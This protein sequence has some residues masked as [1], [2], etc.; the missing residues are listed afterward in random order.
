[1]SRKCLFCDNTKLTK[2]H[3][4]PK[5]IFKYIGGLGNL[6]F[7]PQNSLVGVNWTENDTFFID[8]IEKGKNVPYSDFAVKCVCADCNN[9]WMS[10]LESTVEPILRKLFDSETLG[11]LSISEKEAIQLSCWAILKTI[12]LGRL[13]IEVIEFDEQICNNLK[14]AIISDRFVVEVS[15]S[16]NTYLNYIINGQPEYIP[17]QLNRADLILEAEGFYMGGYQ[18]GN[19][20]FRV[21]YCPP[22]M[23]RMQIN[24]KMFVLFP[25]AHEL[26][27]LDTEFNKYTHLLENPN[28]ELEYLCCLLALTDKM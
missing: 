8:K 4:Y 11:Q 16:E 1:M 15:K 26:P 5:W 25:Y 27:L 6:R 21:S 17:C 13:G 23:H 18:I 19:I 9:G 7:K 22:T 3:I 14:D 10:N 20:M 2:E 24:K 12:V 28:A